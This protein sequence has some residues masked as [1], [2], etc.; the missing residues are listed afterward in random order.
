MGLIPD[1]TKEFFGEFWTAIK[2]VNPFA[3]ALSYGAPKEIFEKTKEDVIQNIIRPISLP[4]FL[5]VVAL[6]LGLIYWK[7]IGKMVGI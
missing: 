4:L 5:I 3:P 1:W 2:K 6:I 7:K